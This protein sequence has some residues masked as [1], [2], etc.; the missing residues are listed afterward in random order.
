MA[1]CPLGKRDTNKSLGDIPARCYAVCLTLIRRTDGRL[2][3]RGEDTVQDV[4]RNVSFGIYWVTTRPIADIRFPIATI[5]F[6]LAARK[7]FPPRREV[8]RRQRGLNA[9]FNRLA[10]CAKEEGAVKT[11]NVFRGY[12][13]VYAP[14]FCCRDPFRRGRNLREGGSSRSLSFSPLGRIS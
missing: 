5:R 10:G 13:R 1:G 12:N 7:R 6:L 14:I 4:V 11:S 2:G 8:D 3:R 9:A